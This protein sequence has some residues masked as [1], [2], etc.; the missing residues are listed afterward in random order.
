MVGVYDGR[1]KVHRQEQEAENSYLELQASVFVP[2]GLGHP[3]P[4]GRSVP[5]HYRALF[6]LSWTKMIMVHEYLNYEA[7]ESSVAPCLLLTSADR[8]GD[9]TV[10]AYVRFAPQF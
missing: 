4:I 3:H 9:T 5:G 1:V 6:R 7:S 2:G 10:V 8:E